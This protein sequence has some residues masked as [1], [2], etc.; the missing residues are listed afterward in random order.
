MS[1]YYYL[2]EGSPE[3]L[4]VAHVI[5]TFFSFAG[6]NLFLNI[7]RFTISY[8][9]REMPNKCRREVSFELKKKINK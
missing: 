7:I 2:C 8:K 6:S 5:S 4:M 1:Y 9:L 3:P